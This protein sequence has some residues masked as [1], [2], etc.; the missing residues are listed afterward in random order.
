VTDE[1]VMQDSAGSTRG[2]LALASTPEV[3]AAPVNPVEVVLNRMH[4]RWLWFAVTAILLAPIGATVA[5]FVTPVKY[6]GQGFV[7]IQYSLDT[8][9]LIR[10]PETEAP[11]NFS[12]FVNEQAILLRSDRVLEEASK[13]SRLQPFIDR[14]ARRGT[15]ELADG[16]AVDAVK[17]TSFVSIGKSSDDPLYSAA[18][19]NSI[20][21]AYMRVAGPD[22]E[23]DFTRKLNA[24]REGLTGIRREIEARQAELSE[25]IRNSFYGSRD[26]GS[27][28]GTKVA[29]L[30]ALDVQIQ[31]MNAI[32]ERIRQSRPAGEAEIPP[33][34]VVEPLIADLVRVDPRIGDLKNNLDRRKLE[35]ALSKDSFKPGHPALQKAQREIDLLEKQLALQQQAASELW[36][37]GEGY[38]PRYSQVIERRKSLE[39]DGERLRAEIST[40]NDAQARS[41]SI[42]RRIA[43]LQGDENRYLERIK[44]L[45]MEEDAIRQGRVSISQYA[46]ARNEPASDKRAMMA[47]MGAGGAAA[48]SFAFFFLLGTLDRRTY[49]SWQLDSGG[50]RLLLA[51]SIPD[52]DEVAADPEMAELATNC[53]H[54]IRTRIESRR[55]PGDGYVIMVSSPF[56]GDGKTTLAV[57]LAW[58]YAESGHRTVLVDSDFVGMALS[59]QFD[60]LKRPGLREV[61]MGA[62]ALG[63]VESLGSPFLSILP[64]GADRSFGASK[65]HPGS[66]RKVFNTLRKGYDII[67]VDTGPMTASI[68]ALPVAAAADGVV[69]SLRRG[70]SRSRLQE[71]IR[72]IEHVGSQ[73]LG[74]VLNFAQ[75]ADCIRYGS[76]SRMS[77]SVSKALEGESEPRAPHPLLTALEGTANERAIKE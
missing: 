23:T 41:E 75:K 36:R 65:V 7:S 22:A 21:D 4:G 30:Q 6:A 58:S 8:N 28:I 57:S 2:E 77:I 25:L 60:K 39:R 26:F 44:Q 67:I 31:G 63:L 34:A 17:G 45:T 42:L 68:E 14:I 35:F 55:V 13:D 73:Y 59:H 3:A 52:M 56:Q 62:D 49:G 18:V 12:Q 20:L 1:A 9:T 24:N 72:E 16:L 29:A 38:S 54:R 40:L 48:A 53:V 19:V 32:V 27:I 61:L 70:R 15:P 71:C 47:M 11:R 50:E 33:D 46:V 64:V 5:W 43:Q 37:T 10:T 69:L 76:V 74:V 66:L 51:G